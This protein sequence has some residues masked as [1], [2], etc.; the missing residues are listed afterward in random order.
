MD[1]L[2]QALKT[3]KLWI[4]VNYIDLR[5]KYCFKGRDLKIQFQEESQHHT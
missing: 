5:L 2:V 3:V 1:A 4:E